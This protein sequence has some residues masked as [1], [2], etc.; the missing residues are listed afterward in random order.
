MSTLYIQRSLIKEL[1]MCLNI[2]H[3][4]RPELFPAT[5]NHDTI[6]SFILVI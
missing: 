5:S 4:H 3:F 2:I 6:A 1:S